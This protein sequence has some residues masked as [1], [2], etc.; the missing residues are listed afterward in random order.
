MGLAPE[1]DSVMQVS[2]AIASDSALTPMEGALDAIA[3]FGTARP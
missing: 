2:R 1:Q 3:A